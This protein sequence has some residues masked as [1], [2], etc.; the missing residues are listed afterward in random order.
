MR[1]DDTSL[2]PPDVYQIE[3]EASG[4]N[5]PDLETFLVPFGFT[6]HGQGPVPVGSLI[7]AGAVSLRFVR[8][9]KFISL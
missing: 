6:E 4:L 1:T 2:F 9:T 5:A 3:D 7:T 8:G